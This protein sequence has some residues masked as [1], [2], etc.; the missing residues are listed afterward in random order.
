MTK[1][2]SDG[3]G[4]TKPRQR[5]GSKAK[6]ILT[7]LADRGPMTNKEIRTTTGITVADVRCT[8]GNLIQSRYIVSE[9]VPVGKLAKVCLHSISNQGRERLSAE[10]SRAPKRQASAPSIWHFANQMAAQVGA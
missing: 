10:L 5:M 9:L 3:S 6:Q 4:Y 7:L 1:S 8:I 2:T